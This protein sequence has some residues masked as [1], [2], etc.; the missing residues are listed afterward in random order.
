MSK[1]GTPAAEK[2][3]AA[4]SSLIAASALT[5]L[6]TIVGFDTNSLG[7]L[8]E[9]LHS[10]I[11]LLAALITLIAVHI[12]AIPADESHPYGHGKVEHLAALAETALLLL[13]CG[14]IIGEAVQRLMYKT[15]MII[16][17]IWAVAVMTISI[18]VDIS[19]SR[20]LRRVAKKH[21]SQA[22]E[23][24]ALHFASDIWSSLI[25]LVGLGAI[26]LS[27]NM[28]PAHPLRP[29]LMHADALAALVVACIVLHACY[30]L[31]KKA[32][33]GLMD[34]NSGEETQ[35]IRHCLAE[36]PGIVR[37]GRIRSRT[38]GPDHFVD[39][40]I[41]VNANLGLNA[42][43]RVAHQ[44]EEAIMRRFPGADV[45]V[46]VDPAADMDSGP[47]SLYPS[48]RR[49]DHESPPT[50]GAFARKGETAMQHRKFGRTSLMV[51]ALGFGCMR[52]PILGKWP[53]DAASIDEAKTRKLLLAAVDAGVNYFDTAWP[54]H[55]G[56][57]ESIVG[58][59]LADAGLRKKTHIATKLP[60]WDIGEPADMERIFAE[61]CKKLRTD[62]ID[63]Y[64][65]HSLNRTYWKKLVEYGALEFLARLKREGRILHAGFSFHDDAPV[66]KEILDGWDWD[67]CQI[68][69]N[70]LDE[71]LQAGTTGFERAVEKGLAVVVMEP[72][73]G[74][75][76][77]RPA[78]QDIQAI[79]DKAVPGRSPADWAL[80]W[81]WDKAGMTVLLS[82]M[83]S[84]EQL[85]EN[86]RICNAAQ[87]G[88]LSDAERAAYA[89]ARELFMKR[90]KVACT[91]CA[92]CMPCPSG[93]SI[94]AVFQLYNDLALF[95]DWF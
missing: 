65:L 73:K 4:L 83:N 13:T 87:A 26:W 19:R 51:S 82:G 44:A 36:V 24:D 47:F 18:L 80:R 23:A 11:D 84:L 63:F 29:L 74:G 55:G 88:G 89:K 27:Q 30:L 92:Y 58:K 54:Y 40:T 57:S 52:L 90:N 76:L 42:A 95:D 34:H 81:L 77:A 72:L 20:M 79:W 22:L 49:H 33:N 62:Y 17:S 32:V 48:I 25:V 3:Q 1:A 71:E 46:H 35:P 12:A 94:P 69:Y 14:W 53:E 64:L 10:G 50:L 6:K 43:H 41:E 93:V 38:S 85:E 60:S 5:V 37:V 45:S 7:M 91:S 28:A 86:C 2:S 31:S 66:F 78:P 8:S 21:K 39:L 59:T 70:F 16:P 75:A 68:Q 67:F 61:Q 9:A 56:N 15:A